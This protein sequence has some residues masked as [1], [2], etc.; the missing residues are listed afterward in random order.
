MA[1]FAF[2]FR[3]SS[4]DELHRCSFPWPACVSGWSPK[5]GKIGIPVVTEND[6]RWLCKNSEFSHIPF[7]V[8]G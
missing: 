7:M 4:I 2:C 3:I 6:F 8:C 1:S 5:V